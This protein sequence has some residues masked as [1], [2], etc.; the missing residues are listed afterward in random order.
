MGGEAG[1]EQAIPQGSVFWFTALLRRGAEPLQVVLPQEPT[2]A[3]AQLRQRHSGRVV[4]LA[5]DNEVNLEIASAMLKA[6]GLRVETAVD[7]QQALLRA[8]TRDYDLVLMDMQ[9]PCMDG[10]E[11][12]RQ[13]RQL[14]DWGPVPILALT[15]NVFDGDRKACEAAGMN[16]FI[17]KPIAAESLYRGVL[18]WLDRCAGDRLDSTSPL[19]H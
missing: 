11:A 15:A 19:K 4:L 1:V 2:D 14:P 8:T 10:L 18:N 13:I 7:G 12:T 16:D 3:E 9:M 6:V 5:E 17:A